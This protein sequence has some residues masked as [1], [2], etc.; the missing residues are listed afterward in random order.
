MT[1]P[2]A[3]RS[4]IATTVVFGSRSSPRSCSRSRSARRFGLVRWSTTTSSTGSGDE[5]A[6]AGRSRGAVQKA[7]RPSELAAAARRL[8]AC[9]TRGCQYIGTGHIISDRRRRRVRVDPR[10]VQ[11]TGRYGDA[12]RAAPA[13]RGRPR[14]STTSRTSCAFAVPALVALVALAAWYFTGRALRPV[15]A[16]RAEA[17]AITGSTMHRRVPEPGTDDEVGRLAQR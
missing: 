10:I 1:R 4:L 9:S 5:P 6:A 13:D 17:E 16:I 8:S 12:R 11:T 7:S 3:P 2:L 15:E 14:P